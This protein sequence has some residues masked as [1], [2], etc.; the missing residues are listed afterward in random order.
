MHA[1]KLKCIV[2]PNGL[3]GNMYGPIE[4]RRHNFFMLRESNMLQQLKLYAFNLNGDPL[5]LYGDPAYP[6]R[7]HVQDPFK[8]ARLLPLE[9]EF[10]MAMSK[11]KVSVE[12]LFGDICNWF[13]FLDFKKNLKINL[14]P[15][16]KMYLVCAL[17]ANAR[18]CL[19]GNMTSDFFNWDPP[20]LE[21]YSR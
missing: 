2:L 6:L 20:S 18:T 7:V 16:G 13:A 9:Q 12:W 4:G 3:I 15:V 5:C 21:E 17:L 8:N 14:S 10:N 19:Y 1:L 11:V